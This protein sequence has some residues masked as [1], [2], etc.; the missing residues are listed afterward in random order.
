MK[1]FKIF[2]EPHNG[3]LIWRS[4]VVTTVRLLVAVIIIGAFCVVGKNAYNHYKNENPPM[5]AEEYRTLSTAAKLSEGSHLDECQWNATGIIK[6]LSTGTDH[7]RGAKSGGAHTVYLAVV[8]FEDGSTIVAKMPQEDWADCTE[9][10]RITVP[11]R[12]C[13][14]WECPTEFWGT[15]WN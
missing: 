8:E 6:R 3:R 2:F 14:D 10:D 11:H 7:T 13:G 4:W 1:N 12:W 5:T 15:I 9:G